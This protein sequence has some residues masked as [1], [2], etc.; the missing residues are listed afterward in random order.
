MALSNE[1]TAMLRL[2]AQGEQGYADI[3]ALMG[4]SEEEVRAKV[5]GALAQLQAE[6]KPAPDVPPPIPGGAHPAAEATPPEP[7]PPPE[8]PAASEAPVEPAIA[9]A[10][11]PR[12]GAGEP[13]APRPVAPPPASPSP[14]D[15][16]SSGGRTITLPTGRNAWLLGGGILAAI[17]IV[18]AVI[19]LA[20]GGGGGSSTTAGDGASTAGREGKSES[21]STAKEPTQAELKAVDGSEASGRATFGR[22]E[23][24]LALQVEATGLE[25]TVEGK[26]SYAILLAQSKQRML[27]LASTAVKGSGKGANAIAAQFEVPVEILGY[28]AN[29]TFDQIVITK[30]E[31][32]RFEEAIEA[33]TK[34]KRAPTYT[35]E[36]ILR[37]T[38]T[39]PIVG[40]AQ[41]E[42]EASE[43]KSKSGGQ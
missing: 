42:K 16:P 37:G 26:N 9:D 38:I 12:E 7:E 43:E 8:P 19:L 15:R 28:L 20:S 4:L 36:E 39:G 11:A 34:K 31:N 24:K 29:G 40:L 13:E 27:P 32:K 2:L 6:G 14:S 22:V 3:A 25:P 21:T 1:Q 30:V 18:V 5:V 23:N 41:R 33:A 35:G 17:A 10:V